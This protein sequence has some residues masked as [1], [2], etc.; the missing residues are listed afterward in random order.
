MAGD[1]ATTWSPNG[2]DW[3]VLGPVLASDAGLYTAIAI[4]LFTDRLAEANDVPPDGSSTRRGWWG[5][6][7]SE[8]P[9]DR[10]GSR[11]WLLARSKQTQPVLRQAEAY[12]REAL[13]WLVE[14]GVAR[15]VQVQAE[16]SGDGVLGLQVQVTRSNEP[17]ARYR[18]EAFWKGN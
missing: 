4:S 9:G 10:I 14:D 1:I 11:L 16:V 2:G 7:Y 18:F 3:L 5:D 13:Q 17:V 12:A 6:A 8:V 15:G